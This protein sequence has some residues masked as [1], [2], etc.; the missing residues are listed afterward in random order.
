MPPVA[1]VIGGS[2]ISG[3]LGV[4][5]ASKQ[6][7]AAKKAG[8]AQ[9]EAALASIE[10]QRRQFDV[11]Q[12]LTA[13]RREA[14]D[15]AINAL[16]GVLGIGGEAPDFQ[17]TP[18]FQFALDRS[19]QAIERSAAAR[20]GLQ[21]GGTLNALQQN[22]IGLAN[23]NFL[24]GLVNPLQNLALG[25]Q[26]AL[27]GQ[28]ALNLGANVGQTL[29]QGAAARASGLQQAAAFQGQGLSSLNRAIQGGL[30]NFLLQGQV[31]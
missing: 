6:A 5:S 26:Q 1:A 22:A 3:G 31:G 7:R 10:E 27:A 8:R 14:E 24:S 2:V 13:P 19:Q 4:L 12:Q 28:N 29:Q 30:S 25:G 23:Q 21:G 11:S 20:G 18:G 17:G 9:E 15:A 16:R